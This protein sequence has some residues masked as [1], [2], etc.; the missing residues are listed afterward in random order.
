M[1]VTIHEIK[2]SPIQISVDDL[3]YIISQH[4][5]DSYA[6]HTSEKIMENKESENFTTLVAVDEK[7]SSILGTVTGRKYTDTDGKCDCIDS[8]K[9]DEFTH[10]RD[11]IGSVSYGYVD[12]VHRGQGIG[13]QLLEKIIE[14]FEN[15]SDVGLILSESYLHESG[16]SSMDIL[17]K[18]GF[19]QELQ[20]NTYYRDYY[21]SNSNE[22]NCEE[23]GK[24][25]NNCVC[26]GAIF[27]KTI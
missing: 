17:K 15:D 27:A 11:V 2:E 9:Y 13:S 21:H 4:T 22:E 26:S 24:P 14:L 7:S 5:T 20:S 8:I 18:Y 10:G 3:Y 16:R 23:C 1:L 12:D 25:K 19:T 6:E